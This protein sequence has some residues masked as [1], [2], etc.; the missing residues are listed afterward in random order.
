ML[1]LLITIIGSYYINCMCVDTILSLQQ[2]QLC[3][4]IKMSVLYVR[5]AKGGLLD[6][7]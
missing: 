4:I 6:V 3:S 5:K 2:C 1:L 7:F